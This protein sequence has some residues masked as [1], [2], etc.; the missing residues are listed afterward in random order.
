M[1]TADV[2]VR[3]K[4]RKVKISVSSIYLFFGALTLV[5]SCSFGVAQVLDNT[6]N[7]YF[8]LLEATS[9]SFSPG[10]RGGY[11]VCNIRLH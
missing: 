6:E 10:M 2:E 8:T 4:I 1:P 5:S 3:E 9:Q 11:L 7:K